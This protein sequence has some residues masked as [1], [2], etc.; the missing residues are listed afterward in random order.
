MRSAVEMTEPWKPWKAKLRFPTVPIDPWESPTLRFPHSRSAGRRV[1]V[2]SNKRPQ[3]LTL[4]PM[5]AIAF[6]SQNQNKG[7]LA[8]SIP[9]SDGS[10]VS[11]SFR[12]GTHSRFQAHG[13]LESKIDF[14]LISGLEN[15]P[16]I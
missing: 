10:Y 2:F 12:M 16:T 1:I 14:R 8:A 11:G 5:S 9:G 6:E 15:A 4:A 7:A 3:Y 13:V